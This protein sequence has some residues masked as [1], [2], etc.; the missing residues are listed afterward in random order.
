MLRI[1][2]SWCVLAVMLTLVGGHVAVL[3]T[4]AWVGM[5][6]SRIDTQGFSGALQST[7]DGQ[8]P[9]RMCLAVRQLRNDADLSPGAAGKPQL[10]V[11]NNLKKTDLSWC[12]DV[13][14]SVEIPGERLVHVVQVGG[15]LTPWLMSPEPPPP[16]L[17]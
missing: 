14:W 6:A 15:V 9:C 4:V 1:W 17:V 13:S 8:H 11:T 10:P 2:R 12:Q 3:Q 16:K 5:V 7:F